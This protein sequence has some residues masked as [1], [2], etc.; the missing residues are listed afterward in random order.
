MITNTT[1]MK[2]LFPAFFTAM[3]FYCV[4]HLSI[5]ASLIEIIATGDNDHRDEQLRGGRIIPRT[6]KQQEHTRIQWTDPVDNNNNNSERRN[7]ALIIS[8]APRRA[9]HVVAL[10]SELECFTTDVDYVILSGPTWSQPILETVVEM[11]KTSIPRFSSSS[12]STVQLK[13][14]TSINDRYDVG[15]WC[16]ALDWMESNGDLQHMQQ[17]SLL[18]DSVFALREYSSILSALQTN[19]A[20]MTSLSYSFIRPEAT[21][22]EHFWVES[23]WRGFDRNGIQTFRD[24]S[25]RP[26]DDPMFCARRWWGK[27]GCIVENFERNMVRQFPRDKVVGLYPSDVPKHMLTRKHHFNTWVRHPPYWQK[28]VEEEGFPVSKVNWPEMIGSVDDDR[29]KTCTRMID[30]HAI[31]SMD[32]SA[33]VKA[34]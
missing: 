5:F 4:V 18:N 2:H 30:R 11:A 10:W 21:G 28:L 26:A 13:F 8:V 7:N 33:A 23:V 29:L 1:S 16:D 12:S 9:K 17:I 19:N 3:A 15:L 27:K 6:A 24:Y 14:Q 31:D 22:P 32:F 34:I 25:C 20:S